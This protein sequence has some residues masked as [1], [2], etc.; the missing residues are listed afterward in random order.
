M[1]LKELRIKRGVSQR[2]VS[3]KI[4]MTQQ[5]YSKLEQGKSGI[6]AKKAKQLA[7][8]L[9]VKLDDLIKHL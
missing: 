3:E 5:Q 4:G 2:Y 8:T 9:G 7:D 1:S 6:E